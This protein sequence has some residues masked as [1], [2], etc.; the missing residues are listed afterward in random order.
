MCVPGEWLHQLDKDLHRSQRS[1]FA[2]GTVKNMKSQWKKF[3][4]FSSLSG[5]DSLPLSSY[6]LC[7]YIQFLSRSLK[8]PQSVRNYVSGLKTLHVL[9]D[10][11]FPSTACIDVRLTL[12][13][14]E[15]LLHHVPF[16][17]FPVTPELLRELYDLLDP[18]EPVD[19]VFWCLF[20]FL[21]FLFARK[22]QFI[23][24]SSLKFDRDKL[25]CRKD[26]KLVGDQLHVCFN[27]TIKNPSVWG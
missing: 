27:W 23:P 13:G 11:P 20:L 4:E 12:R 26:V 24:I 10:L 1:A 19:S 21:F 22:S 15:R 5:F 3:S 14:V 6:Q 2:L 17:A 8:S 9:L 25:V 16:Q 18:Q 7:L